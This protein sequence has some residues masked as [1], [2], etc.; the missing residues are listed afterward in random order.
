M[1]PVSRS[2]NGTPAPAPETAHDPPDGSTDASA[3]PQDAIPGA[4]AQ[5]SPRRPLAP[6]VPNLGA[7]QRAA[8]SSA[9]GSGL[10]ASPGAS[11]S[12]PSDLSATWWGGPQRAARPAGDRLSGLAQALVGDALLPHVAGRRVLDLGHGSPEIAQWVRG[13][14]ASLETVEVGPS[15]S[16]TGEISL[17]QSDARYDV[18]YSVRTL[19]HLGHDEASSD[20]AVRS[21]LAE[22]ARVV[23]PGGTLLVEINNPRSLRGLA[24]GIRRPITIVS[25]GG[26]VVGDQ[27]N[28]TRYDTL[29]RLLRLTPRTLELARVYGIRVLVPIARA[30]NIPL[31]GRLLAAGEW[32]A[33]DSF[34]R[35]FGAHLLVALRRHDD[36]VRRL[37]KAPESG[38]DPSTK[39]G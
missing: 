4:P 5:S 19:A 21:L 9:S 28:V 23:V 12:H 18:V 25:G 39:T 27:R 32:W 37:I 38:T 11:Q 29:S 14:A 16:S 30:F 7:V 35:G 1:E 22:A 20:L 26:V 10:D 17:M 15:M 33:R 3:A 36:P 2:T 34:L 6:R 31:I 13:H 8:P 24:Y